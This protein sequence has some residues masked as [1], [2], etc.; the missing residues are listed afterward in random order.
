MSLPTGTASPLGFVP[1]HFRL[2]ARGCPDC[3]THPATSLWIWAGLGLQRTRG[4]ALAVVTQGQTWPPP[5]TGVTGRS[6]LTHGLL[7]GAFAG[8]QQLSQL[9]RIQLSTY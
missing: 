4:H 5:S 9:W 7:L 6:G 2:G 3:G 1:L 8:K